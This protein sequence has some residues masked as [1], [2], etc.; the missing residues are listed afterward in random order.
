MISGGIRSLHLR[1]YGSR[2][3]VDDRPMCP[4]S[5]FTVHKMT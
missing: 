2:L 5:V 4:Q 3:S 1:G